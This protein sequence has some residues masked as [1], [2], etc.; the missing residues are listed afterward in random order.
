ME[1]SLS[2]VFSFGEL[3]Q[4]NL[5]QQIL[6]TNEKSFKYG[7]MLTQEQAKELAICKKE[8]LYEEQ[9]IEFKES[10]ITKIIEKFCES[11]YISKDEYAETMA[12]LT[13]IFFETKNESEDTLADDEL[14]DVMFILFENTSGGSLE[15]LRS[16]D[17]EAIC[18]NIRHG[19]K[20]IFDPDSRYDDGLYDEKDD[21]LEEN[22]DE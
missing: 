8:T 11:T 7:L 2:N 18:R 22:F 14:I 3:S 20:N 1:F 10:A 6:E 21:D 15:C 16:R 17:L 19:A 5:I 9:R 12:Q 4:L 13:E